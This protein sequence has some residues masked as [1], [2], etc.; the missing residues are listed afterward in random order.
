MSA[1]KK[2]YLLDGIQS[3]AV[4]AAFAHVDR[5]QFVPP[6]LKAN[7]WDD[8]PLP[9]KENATI[10]QPSLVAKMTEL[11]EAEGVSR[12][13]EIGTG[14]GYQTA[15]LA[16]LVNE[17]YTIEVNAKLSTSAAERLAGLGYQNVHFRIGDG[18]V[19]WPEAAPFDRIIATAAFDQRPDTVLD[20]LAKN[21]ICIAPVGPPGGMQWLIRYSKV[22]GR[23]QERKLTPVI[24]ISMRSSDTSNW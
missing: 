14:S 9:I 1:S 23:L 10:S 4:R 5:A 12:V 22:S 24:F 6:H 11:L 8:H 18:A 7:A 15:L 3:D 2:E 19:G 13:L 16:E 21:G 17:V 20:Q